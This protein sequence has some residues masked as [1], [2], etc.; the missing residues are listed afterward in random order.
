[1]LNLFMHRSCS[2]L[3]GTVSGIEDLGETG[4]VE[5]GIKVFCKRPP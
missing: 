3:E 5:E 1:M 2:N 4:A